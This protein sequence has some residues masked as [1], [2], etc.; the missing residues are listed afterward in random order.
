MEYENAS[1]DI[2][3][4]DYFMAL[5]LVYR[6]PLHAVNDNNKRTKEKH[7]LRRVFHTQILSVN[8]RPYDLVF[9]N[10]RDRRTH[11][12]G[13]FRFHPLIC[14]D[15]NKPVGCELDIKALSHDPFGAVI[16]SG[17]IDNRLK[18][19]FDALCMPNKDQIKDSE[20][21]AGENPFWVL[22]SDD[23]SITDFHFTQEILRTPRHQDPSYIE[24]TITVKVKP[25]DV[26]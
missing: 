10:A 19:L 9:I 17:D 16:H 18:L 23:K 7:A 1:E 26:A 25:I 6:G 8:K 22:M 24:L 14:R 3:P 2:S 11:E 5:T 20:P 15:P 12:I 13:S 21:E 4:L